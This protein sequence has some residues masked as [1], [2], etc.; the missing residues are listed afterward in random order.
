MKT[1][2]LFNKLLPSIIPILLLSACGGGGGGTPP[3]DNNTTPPPPAAL[4]VMNV[5]G[6]TTVL[7]GTWQSPCLTLGTD[8][9]RS[10]M[11]ISGTTM[12][13]KSDSWTGNTSCAGVATTTTSSTAT[14][15]VNPSAAAI[16]GWDTLDLVSLATSTATA[17]NAADGSGPLSDNE[18]F[19]IIDYTVTA[20]TG[21]QAPAVGSTGTSAYVVD[22]TGAYPILY[23]LWT[24]PAVGAVA[25]VNVY[26]EK[27]YLSS[28]D[29][30]TMSGKSLN[31]TG[32]WSSPCIDMGGYGIT[33]SFTVTADDVLTADSITY[34]DI[35]C[36]TVSAET[37]Y[38]GVATTGT[39][40]T[41]TGWVDT[42]SNTTP[43]TGT[44]D[45]TP[46]SINVTSSSDPNLIGMTVS[47]FYVVDDTVPST[48]SLFQG[49][50]G[51]STA[52]NWLS[53]TLL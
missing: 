16:A 45:Y 35:T 6:T 30:V 27:P 10:T 2:Q 50:G 48:P 21:S 29:V 37:T 52:Y 9:E 7:D 1:Q 41:L 14:G 53:L 4:E 22:D 28:L 23:Q 43:V 5:S 33:V 15:T 34:G 18:P 26:Y 40:A 46:I 24:D 38:S 11:T 13:T 20:S 12:T 17:P 42:S 51:T 25:L 39:V 49:I 36:A 44:I 32:S 19:S 47:T 31:L 3:A 8:S